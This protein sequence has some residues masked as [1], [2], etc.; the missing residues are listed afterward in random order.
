M[1][2]G[3]KT[4]EY[5]SQEKM[6][7]IIEKLTRDQFVRGNDVYYVINEQFQPEVA[8]MILEAED[9][10]V[11][12]I[13]DYRGVTPAGN[14]DLVGFAQTLY[15]YLAA[16]T[17]RV[18]E[19]DDK[20]KFP[21][22]LI[23]IDQFYYE[24]NKGKLWL[25]LLEDPVGYEL[26]LPDGY[27]EW[28]KQIREAQDQLRS[29]VVNSSRLQEQLKRLGQEWLEN[30]IKV[31]VNIT[32]PAD[33]SFRS[34]HLIDNFPIAPDI[35][36]RDHRKISFYDITELDPGK[37][38]AIYGGLGIGEHYSGPTWEDRA[39][40]MRGP[41]LVSLKDAARRVLLQ[42]GFRESEIPPPLRKMP[43]PA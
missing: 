15:G 33:F 27:E 7:A 26:Y 9:Y 19:Y 6:D 24:A 43:K 36:M 20:G 4:Y 5:D 29:A 12:W 13:H 39:I 8:R 21:T 11:L 25:D 1:Q 22:Y 16:M 2:Y 3:L 32:N 34:A 23:I 18:R 42:Q 40:L 14:P 31:H 38:E 30:R 28:E 10:H 35:L 17:D 37:G 41:V